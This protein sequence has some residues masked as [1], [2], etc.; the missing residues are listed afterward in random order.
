MIIIALI[1]LSLYLYH[2]KEKAAWLL[3]SQAKTHEALASPDISGHKEAADWVAD[4]TASAERARAWTQTADAF[5][6]LL[7]RWTLGSAGAL[8][9]LRIASA[10]FAASAAAA[11]DVSGLAGWTTVVDGIDTLLWLAAVV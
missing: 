6:T 4:S 9:V 5:A 3:V 11:G 1:L 10:A 8:A 7:G 2:P